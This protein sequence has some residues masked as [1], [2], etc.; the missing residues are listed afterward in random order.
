[1]NLRAFT[2]PRLPSGGRGH[3]CRVALGALLAW[4][5]LG[6]FSLRLTHPLAFGED[7]LFLLLHGRL[8]LEWPDILRNGHLGFPGGINLL[9]FPFSDLTQRLLQF[10]GTMASGR[11]FAGAHAYA[12]AVVAANVATAYAALQVFT[13]RPGQALVGAV[14]FATIPFFTFRLGSHDYLAAFYPA[15]LAFILL[16]RLAGTT[17]TGRWLD[18]WRGLA[19][20]PLVWGCVGIIATSGI[21]YSFF[22]VM[23]LGVGA[24]A[25]SLQRRSGRPLLLVTA[26]LVPILAVLAL[27]LAPSV[28]T[29]LREGA[30]FPQRQ[31]QEQ[32]LYGT[33]L[34]NVL[35]LFDA[36]PAQAL[37]RYGLL[38]DQYE[39][40]DFWPGPLLSVFVLLAC[41]AAP[42]LAWPAMA[43]PP[44]GSQA[45][46]A[47]MARVVLAY[48]CFAL[49]FTMP[50]GLGMVFN[51]LVSPVIRA[52]NRIAP[53]FAFGALLLALWNWRGVAR[54]LAL[55]CGRRHGPRLALL[56]LAVLAG[57]NG[58]ASLGALSRKQ[59]TLLDSP[60]YQQEVASLDRILAAAQAQGPSRVLQLPIVSWPEQPRIRDFEPYWHM[61][62]FI[63]SPRDSQ[64][65]WSYGQT[66]PSAGL[67]MLR[68]AQR[69]GSPAEL[70][71]HLGCLGF[72]L[73]LLER[74]AFTAEAAGE[75]DATLR[76]GGAALL[77]E[78]GLR[79]LYRL[80]APAQPGCAPFR[81]PVDEW[82][83][84]T[85][86]GA[87]EALL[88]PGWNAADMQM[89]WGDSRR[90][91]LRL[92]VAAAGQGDLRLDIAA[93]VLPREG[94]WRRRVILRSAGEVLGEWRFDNSINLAERSLVI[95]RRLLPAA[96]FATVQLD[97]DEAEV[98]GRWAH[99]GDTRLL[100]VALVLL[101]LGEAR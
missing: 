59:R 74:R 65:Q 37:Q 27:V 81:F 28:L 56:A 90:H 12:A 100:G 60:D 8:F 79:R 34:A 93:W 38:A 42:T 14:V 86:G 53:F 57:M 17:T 49:L 32:G 24:A 22:S 83:P 77:L 40:F 96:G 4:A 84:A 6:G 25:L 29:E 87:A 2:L 85:A 88:G 72:D 55:R 80:N 39:G 75:W 13:R 20:Q 89:T 76:G 10:L 68:L 73:V 41:L 64:L 52:Q 67:A 36:W 7:H 61:R 11:V 33:R 21:Y 35:R 1:M 50:W 16:H 92:P 48:L 78:D 91:A 70:P 66:A 54:W 62:P 71:A 97:L 51:V 44:A 69:T 26:L 95:P 3:A 101:R 58:A 19:L 47:E 5:L 15:P 82:L 23:L 46:R 45:R 31:F 98:A 43:G 94:T 18:A 9:A 99:N 30:Q 63:R